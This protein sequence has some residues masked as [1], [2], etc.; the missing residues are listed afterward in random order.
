VA[1]PIAGAVQ[2]EPQKID[3]FWL[4]F[5][6]LAMPSGVWQ[7]R[8]IQQMA[9]SARA[10]DLLMYAAYN[11]DF[12]TVK[13][14]LSHGVSINTTDYAYWRTALHAAASAGDLRT[15]QFL[16][17]SGVDINALDRAGDSPPS[18][19]LRRDIRSVHPFWSSRAERGFGETK[20]SIRT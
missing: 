11:K 9:P 8:F 5:G 1:F 4:L 20:P 6:L 15:I 19:P 2:R 12:G 18:W 16:V 17:S 14:M 13:A 10:G 7:R 3:R